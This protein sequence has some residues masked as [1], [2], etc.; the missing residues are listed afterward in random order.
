MDIGY[1]GAYLLAILVLHGICSILD[2][3]NSFSARVR[4][5]KSS[6]VQAYFMGQIPAVL[7]TL[8][9]ASVETVSSYWTMASNFFAV[10]LIT[11]YSYEFTSQYFESER[12]AR[13]IRKKQTLN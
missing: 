12:I 7:M 8:Q 1:T 9:S 11:V 4:I 3:Q 6:L 13:L 2:L 10:W 5:L